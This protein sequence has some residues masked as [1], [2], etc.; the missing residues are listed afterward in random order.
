MTRALKLAVDMVP[1]PL[2]GQSLYR[3][4][5]KSRWQKLRSSILD[6]QGL[7]CACCNRA[8]NESKDLQA[9]EI[10]LYEEGD[11][12]NVARLSEIN[13]I[14]K[15]CHAVEHMGN[16]IMRV[17]EGTLSDEYI[18]QLIN[19]FCSVNG[20]DA[21]QFEPHFKTAADE[22]NRR[23][24]LAWRVEYGAFAELLD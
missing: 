12:E 24:A 20:I 19:H 8:V 23:S 21:E 15:Q 1:R 6:E 2:F 11:S 16:T 13:L 5:R 7:V 18:P 9:H 10:W 14:C 4:A 17:R 3:L 22:W